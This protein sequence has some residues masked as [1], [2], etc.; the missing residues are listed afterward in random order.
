VCGR[1]FVEEVLK[2]FAE[3]IGVLCSEVQSSDMVDQQASN[4]NTCFFYIAVFCFPSFA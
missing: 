1:R 3:G 2:F 4:P